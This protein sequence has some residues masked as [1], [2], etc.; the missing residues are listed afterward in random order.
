[1]FKISIF[2]KSKCSNDWKN[3]AKHE[4]YRHD[5]RTL[6]LTALENSAVFIKSL[7]VIDVYSFASSEDYN[8]L[9]TILFKLLM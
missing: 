8:I 4:K 5:K 6:T 7:F 2:T 9:Y 3:S 1:M